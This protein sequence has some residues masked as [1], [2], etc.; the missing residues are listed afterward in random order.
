M[1]SVLARSAG[2]AAVATLWSTLL[3]AALLSGFPLLGDRPL[4]WMVADPASAWLFRAG[5]VVA[6]VLFLVFSG[7][8]RSQYPVGRLFSIA[9]VAGMAC[10]IVAALVPIDGSPV[11]HRVHTAAAL[12]LGASLPFFMWR[13]AAA[14]PPGAWRRLAYGLFWA[15]AAACAA[16]VVLSRWS[17]APLAEIVPAACFHLWVAVLTLSRPPRPEAVAGGPG[18]AS[19]APETALAAP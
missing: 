11:E 14:Q 12:L 8:I 13:F 4:S 5:L 15:E 1:T 7:R 3:A 10:Q 17:V 16:G 2:L 18:L 19:T 6:A 9:F